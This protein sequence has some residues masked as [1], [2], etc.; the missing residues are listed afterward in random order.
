[1]SW[2]EA[3]FRLAWK[4]K[5]GRRHAAAEP[6]RQRAARLA[7]LKTSLTLV[8]RALSGETLEIQEAE[9]VGGYAGE[10][11]YLPRTI[12]LAPTP[13]DNARVYLYRVAYAVT[14]RRLG[15]T[16]P[17]G[18][19]AG[20]A[21]DFRAFR[22]LVAVPLTRQALDTAMP[23]C[24]AL[25][26]AFGS[27]LLR[28]RPSP[29]H[30]DTMGGRLEALR[31]ALLGRHPEVPEPLSGLLRR[32]VATSESWDDTAL[33]DLW[34]QFR[35]GVR[36]APR[37]V[38]SAPLVLW[39]QLMPLRAEARPAAPGSPQQRLAA[40]SFPIGTELPGKPKENVR[41][42]VMDQKDID[43]DTLIHTFEKIET[44]EEFS[45]VT[46]TPD[47]ADELAHHADALDEL[48]LREVVR[49]NTPTHSVYKADLRLD[50]DTGD[51]EAAESQ[52][53]AAFAYD[54]WDGRA[55][56][57][58]PAWCTVYVNRPTAPAGADQTAAAILRKHARVVHEVRLLLDKLRHKRLLRN[59]Q[60]EGTDIDVDAVVDR[61]ATVRGGQRPDDRLYLAPRRQRRDLATLL[62][63]DMSASTDA[64]IEGARV[65]DIATESALVL[66]EVLSQWGDRVGMAGFYSNTRRDC[67]F[68]MLKPFD[69][70]WRRSRAALTGLE[71]T[72]Y[73]R[74]GPAVRHGTALLQGQRAARKLLLL[75]SDGKP[76]DYD[77]YEG[78]YGIADIR[79]AIREAH[80]RR[81]HTYALA[82]D[83][84]AK[85]YLPQMFGGGSFRILPHPTHLVR[86]LSEVYG[87][88][89]R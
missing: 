43:N 69:A 39:G 2:D 15:F 66:G 42:V 74:I 14:S 80:H 4:F 87:Q 1:M 81:I 31:Q 67:R 13:D 10:V 11:I 37:R 48:D 53:G 23:A 9:H 27:L 50:D 68:V 36:R 7:D 63:I 82:I 21:A 28:N 65:L 20:L 16:L 70:D 18:R 71:P 44:A 40:S 73:T 38:P 61:Y 22:T 85:L 64:W 25:H 57:Y 76:I 32:I 46:R 54:E 86:G 8:A 35:H 33:H 60:S 78:R 83:V 59:R 30:L 77:R 79:Q 12:H 56:R 75:L 62:L 84:Q 26:Q 89:A 34:R 5:R 24:Q 19:P 52:A 51:L 41:R 58:R 49:S 72:G 45:G 55:Q 6:E 88:L 3:L 47:G 29:A 17:P